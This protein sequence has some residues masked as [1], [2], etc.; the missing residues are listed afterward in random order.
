MSRA[1]E[2]TLDALHGL[3]AGVLKDEL[4]AAVGRAAEKKE[5]ISPQLFDKIMKFL[6]DNGVDTPR[7]SKRVADL[8]DFLDDLDLDE[9]AS[10]PRRA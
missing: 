5:P 3:L 10:L 1:T 4:E 8:E 7:S 2:D 9:V 6:K